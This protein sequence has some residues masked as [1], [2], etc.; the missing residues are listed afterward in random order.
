MIVG[1]R[2]RLHLLTTGNSDVTIG[3]HKIKGVQMKKVLEV[4]I[5]DQLKWDKHNDEQCRRI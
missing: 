5:D 4:I 2:Q 3:E 1:S